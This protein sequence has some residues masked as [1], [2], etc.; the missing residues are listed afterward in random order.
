MEWLC[1][2]LCLRKGLIESGGANVPK[3]RIVCENE[4]YRHFV[5]GETHFLAHLVKDDQDV[6]LSRIDTLLNVAT[7]S[8][9]LN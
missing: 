3:N 2:P 9:V 1:C 7:R 4:F 5:I 6:D 8:L